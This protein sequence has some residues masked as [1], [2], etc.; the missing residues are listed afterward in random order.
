MVQLYFLFGKIKWPEMIN[1]ASRTVSS[2][3]ASYLRHTGQIS[4]LQPISILLTAPGKNGNNIYS[5]H[6]PAIKF[7]G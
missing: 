6:V 2:F 4:N 7:I 1:T 3:K 5:F